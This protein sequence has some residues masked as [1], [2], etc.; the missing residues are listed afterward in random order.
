V[1]SASYRYFFDDWGIKSH[2]VDMNYHWKM[3]D[4]HYLEPRIRYYAQSEAD[5]YR[6]NLISGQPAP[7]E[8]SADYRL[9][10]FNGLTYGLKWGWNFRDESS[11]IFR[12]IIGMLIITNN[13]TMIGLILTDWFTG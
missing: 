9:A 2:T 1:V 7:I 10:K 12:I 13:L 11:L 8:A 6:V 5:F 4:K 3:T